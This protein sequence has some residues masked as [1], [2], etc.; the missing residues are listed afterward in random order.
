MT[1][2]IQE[3]IVRNCCNRGA[4]RKIIG[5]LLIA[6]V[7]CGRW[8]M[9]ESSLYDL[10]AKSIDGSM[11]SLSEYK[12]QVAVVVNVASHCGYT[13][14]Y[15]G[16]QQIYERYKDRGLVVLGFPSND[17]GQ[18]EPGSDEEIKQFCSSRFGVTFPMFSKVKVLGNDNSPV[19]A[20]LVQ[21]TGGSEVG[22]NFEK[23][24]VGK[25]GL[26]LERF[27]SGVRPDSEAFTAAIEKALAQ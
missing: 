14:Q 23:F 26:V 19:Y 18:Q 10:S 2:V 17:F 5:M 1:A 13:R 11:K 3:T 4:L 20:L 21:S 16:L 27:P 7:C 24:L 15:E 22:W 9:A 25:N 8:C 12:G 6:I